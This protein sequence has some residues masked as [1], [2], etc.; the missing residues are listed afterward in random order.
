MKTAGR[1]RQSG[2]HAGHLALQALS[3]CLRSLYL[4]KSKLQA[5]HFE[6]RRLRAHQMRIATATLASGLIDRRGTASKYIPPSLSRPLVLPP[7]L[8]P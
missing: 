8:A 6:I 1:K 3:L 4:P 2:R 5:A 7:T